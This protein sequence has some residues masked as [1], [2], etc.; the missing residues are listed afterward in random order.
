[1][2]VHIVL[3]FK[4]NMGEISTDHPRIFADKNE[5]LEIRLVQ[6]HF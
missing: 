6:A 2:K 1:M 5:I 4:G 3:V